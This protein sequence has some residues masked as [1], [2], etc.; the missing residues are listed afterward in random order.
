MGR[1]TGDQYVVPLCHKHHM[2]L[3]ESPMSEAKFWAINGIDPIV[4]ADNEYAK[5]QK[6]NE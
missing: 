6:E 4:W 2:D 3:H 5:W 1:K